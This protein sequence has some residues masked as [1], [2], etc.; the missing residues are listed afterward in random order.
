[1]DV[2]LF[3]YL[4]SFS[5]PFERGPGCLFVAGGRAFFIVGVVHFSSRPRARRVFVQ[6]LPRCH[7]RSTT[8]TTCRYRFAFVTA[9]I[10]WGRASA[11]IP[12]GPGMHT[13]SDF[14]VHAA[15][16][17]ATAGH[18][19]S[20]RPTAADCT[21]LLGDQ[22]PYLLYRYATPHFHFSPPFAI[23]ANLPTHHR[24]SRQVAYL[25]TLFVFLSSFLQQHLFTA[26]CRGRF[27]HLLF[28]FYITVVIFG[29]GTDRCFPMHSCK[30][31]LGN[32][33]G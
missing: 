32:H 13:T 22:L 29:R 6:H 25:L 28:S 7:G 9:W 15:F 10:S 21:V 1:M 17:A 12:A 30:P 11:G 20:C 18:P 31:R 4:P 26:F 24:F 8:T 16:K 19:D 27:L 33:A 14:A 23:S 5:V 2:L 3:H